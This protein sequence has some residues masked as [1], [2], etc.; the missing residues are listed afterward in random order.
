MLKRRSNFP[1]T[2][3]RPS[4]GKMARTAAGSF[5]GKAVNHLLSQAV[6]KVSSVSTEKPTNSDTRI[7]LNTTFDTTSLYTRKKSQGKKR[8]S[9][10]TIKKRKTKRAFKKKV[11]K[12]LSTWQPWNNVQILYTNVY[13]DDQPTTAGFFTRQYISPATILGFPYATGIGWGSYLTG[14][15]DMGIIEQSLL[16]V[17]H[18]ENGVAQVD[19]ADNPLDMKYYMKGSLHINISFLNSTIAETES[20]FV[21]VYECTAARDIDITTNGSYNTPQKCWEAVALD[22]DIPQLPVGVTNAGFADKGKIPSDCPG[23]RKYWTI[24]QV[25]RVRVNGVEDEF[26]FKLNT[27]GVITRRRS[28]ANVCLKGITKALMCVVSPIGAPTTTGLLNVSYH[29]IKKF[30]FKNM[31]TPAALLGAQPRV[32]WSYAYSTTT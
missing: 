27:Q 31:N 5:A 28:A 17:G 14:T 23:F 22:E 7:N 15:K 10:A 25:T 9:K 30:K 18:V 4:W 13:L 19:S 12:V 1:S 8:V 16:G 24:D 2:Y 6:K 21:D 32:G 26:Q 20:W 11:T 29:S 3:G